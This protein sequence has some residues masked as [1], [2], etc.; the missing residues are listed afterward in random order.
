M[1]KAY[2]NSGYFMLLLIPL[3]ILGFY[4]TYFSQFPDFNEKITM[5][6]HLHAAIASVWIL[7]LIIQPLLI[8]HRRYKIHKMIGKISYIIFPVL[9]LSFIPMMLRIIYSDHPVNLFFP[10]A[11]CTLLILFYSLA[12]Y[13]RKNTPKHMRYMIG[14]AIVFLGPTFGRIAP[15]I[16]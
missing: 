6:H 14:A 13:N 9:I 4:K 16:K 3:V 12:V 8:R 5:F 7:T 2:K 15:Y 10:I 11:D 1:D